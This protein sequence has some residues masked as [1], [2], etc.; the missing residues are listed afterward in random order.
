MKHLM[1]NHT[2]QFFQLFWGSTNADE[3]LHKLLRGLNYKENRHTNPGGSGWRNGA[4]VGGILG[5]E[6]LRDP[7]HTLP[8]AAHIETSV[9]MP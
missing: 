7:S 3:L 9:W 1:Q 5:I 4:K 6:A 8:I 2:T